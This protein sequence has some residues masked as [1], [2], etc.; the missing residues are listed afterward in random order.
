MKT[1]HKPCGVD[2]NGVNE[3]KRTADVP[4]TVYATSGLG[5]LPRRS[6]QKRDNNE[7]SYISQRIEQPKVD[8]SA[9]TSTDDAEEPRR[10]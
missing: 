10:T 2:G 3:M 7:A 9:D 6:G 1:P 8:T 4:S 5:Y